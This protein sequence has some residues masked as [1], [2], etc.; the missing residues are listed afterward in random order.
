MSLI[1]PAK[2]KYQYSKV[3]FF[4]REHGVEFLKFEWNQMKKF[5]NSRYD[6]R[7][8]IDG[9]VSWSRPPYFLLLP[10]TTTHNGYIICKVE[11]ELNY[12]DLNQFS[13]IK[14]KWQVDMIQG[15]PT[16]VIIVSDVNKAKP[17]FGKITPDI[18]PKDFVGI[19][20]E[21]WRNIREPTE[22]L[23]AQ[24][25][26]SSPT[27]IKRTGGFTL[28]LAN[29][30]KKNT[31][32][33]F[34]RDLQ[35]FI[36]SDFTKNKTM[37]FTVPELGITSNLPKFGWEDH[38]SNLESLS[39]TVNEKLNRIPNSKNECSITLLQKTMGPIDFDLR[40]IIKSDYPL[41][42]EENIERI[43]TSHDVDPEV[44]KFILATRMST[45]TISSDVYNQSIRKCQNA[46]SK[47]ADIHKAFSTRTGDNQFFDLGYK[48]KSLSVYN[49]AISQSRADA[50]D[51]I[52]LEDVSKAS[53]LYIENL[54]DILDVQEL[55]GYEKIPPSVSVTLE[56]RKIYLLLQ[57]HKEQNT[58]QIAEKLKM[59]KKDAARSVKMLIAKHLLF[60]PI[61]NK[62]SSV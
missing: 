60:E 52:N 47:F 7:V 17:E 19:L 25:L 51:S 49:L 23:I 29:Y 14:G 45:P 18:S 41:V 22:K 16:K 9:Y 31:L 36:P 28:T 13:T 1:P 40:G 6:L 46:L 56:E 50:D 10:T 30:S 26:I 39:S 57:D 12:P 11:D 8:E 32:T 4:E 55:W 44:Y 2:P 15:R 5:A 43:R 20:F 59:P 53:K 61:E 54:N 38:V 27:E 37:S 3:R 58:L 35:R 33:S 42:L 62:Y 48:G 21:K 24:S 34:L